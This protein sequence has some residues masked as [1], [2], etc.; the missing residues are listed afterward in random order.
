[1][2]D[3]ETQSLMQAAYEVEDARALEEEDD[4]EGAP[5]G[6]GD[7]YTLVELPTLPSL[8][9]FPDLLP[10]SLAEASHADEPKSAKIAAS[11]SAPATSSKSLRRKDQSKVKKREG[12]IE[13]A[14]SG[15]GNGRPRS[16]AKIL[17]S[18]PLVIMKSSVDVADL[19]A[20]ADGAFIGAPFRPEHGP[21]VWS[22][23]QLIKEGFEEIIWGE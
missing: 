9:C 6:R 7:V 14:V 3:M 21:E 19:P 18:A 4:A 23:E 13:R 5:L 12:R 16:R 8:E 20:S 17:K 2:T 22:E 15:K 10:A 1:M 11:M